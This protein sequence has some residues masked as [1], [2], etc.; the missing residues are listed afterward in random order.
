MYK[1]ARSPALASAFRASKVLINVYSV[2]KLF[3]LTEYRVH[4]HEPSTY[5]KSAFS[6]S[7]N[8]SQRT[9]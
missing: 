7:M 1:L 6:R 9:Y 4:H 8:T 2:L 5:S 3:D